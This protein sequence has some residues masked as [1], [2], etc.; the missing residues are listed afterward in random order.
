M[1]HNPKPPASPPEP[2]MTEEQR[3]TVKIR[4]RADNVQACRV[5]WDEYHG[6][7][8]PARLLSCGHSF[9]TRCVVSCSNPE[10]QVNDDNDEIRCP[11]CRR[12]SKQPP[13]TFPVNFQL[14]QILT[15]LSLLRTPR[16]EEE[17]EKELPSA[18]FD[19]LGTILPVNKM[20]E[21]SMT[22]LMHHGQVYFDALRHRANEDKPKSGVLLEIANTVMNRINELQRI[23][24]DFVKSWD[25]IKKGQQP[26]QCWHLRSGMTVRRPHIQTMQ[27][28]L[29]TSPIAAR[30]ILDPDFMR[31][32]VVYRP[33][34]NVADYT[35]PPVDE[36][37]A[38]IE[39]EQIAQAEADPARQIDTIREAHMRRERENARNQE[40][41]RLLAD[42][43]TE[44]ARFRLPS[45]VESRLQ[46]INQQ[47]LYPSCSNC[48]GPHAIKNCEKPTILD[49]KLEHKMRL[50][51]ESS[52][53]TTSSNSAGMPSS[54]IPPLTAAPVVSMQAPP[55]PVFHMES[56]GNHPN[57]PPIQMNNTHFQHHQQQQMAML[58]NVFHNGA[59]FR[60]IG[61][62]EAGPPPVY[63]M[64]QQT[65]PISQQPPTVPSATPTNG[66]NS[67]N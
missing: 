18:N 21:L 20:K 54:S 51:P 44:V 24:E 25:K 45:N 9:C 39:Q 8:N 59:Q 61:Q 65:A 41:M 53:S 2:D 23:M 40:L 66:G 38:V 36:L 7:R 56:N 37:Q 35:N 32:M 26:R 16:S 5:C 4:E 43:N 19:T 64:Q 15:T 50:E 52:T 33:P 13:A 49:R 29:D 6:A 63:L 1:E 27:E 60:P 12:V 47:T 58:Q 3:L 57:G 22:D 14:M 48:G 34:P 28:I 67:S 10:M 31:D 55:N 17:E 11:E 62:F 42:G 46:E 30:R